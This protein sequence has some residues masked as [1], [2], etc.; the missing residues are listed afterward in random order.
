MSQYIV[1]IDLG[2]THT[3]V[4]YALS[5]AK[6]RPSIQVLEIPQQVG[7]GQVAAPKMLP[8]ARYHLSPDELPGSMA[9]LPW[10]E[11]APS[12]PTEGAAALIGSWARQ[13]GA[14]SPGRLVTSA[15]S[16][17]SHAG[18]DRH[19]PVLPWGAGDDANKISPVQ[20]NA[21]YLAHVRAAW[22][23][24]FPRHPLAQQD[25]VLTVPA[26]FDESARAL[27]L[28]AAQQAGLGQLRLLEEPQA[29]FYDWSLRHR[30]TLAKDLSAVRLVLVCD[31]GGGTTDLSLIRV[32]LHDGEPQLTRIGVGDHLMLGG[33]NMDLALAHWV[34]AQLAQAAPEAGGERLSASRLAQLVER[35][36]S[37]KEQLL[38]ANAPEQTTVTLLGAGQRLVGASRSVALSR[39]T[40]EAL[41]LDGFFPLTGPDET[42]RSARR[43]IVELG[44]PY[45][46]DPAVTRHV[47]AFLRQH[48]V[49]SGQGRERVS[50]A[51][52]DALLLNGGVFHAPA[53]AERLQRQLE[54]WRGA[55][56][57]VLNNANPD[58]AVARGAVAYR[59][60]Q[61]GLGQRIRSGSARSYFLLLEGAASKPQGVCVLARGSDAG[62]PFTL[63]GQQFA[64]RLGQ[65]VRFHLYSTTSDAPGQAPY[66]LGQTVALDGE[67]FV[68]LPPIATVLQA[69]PGVLSRQQI[70]VQ[71]VS[72][73]SEVGT[74]E[75]HC[76]SQSKP[77]QRWQ[78]AFDL[79]Q[80]PA[81]PATQ[82]DSGPAQRRLQEAISVLDQVFGT[83]SRV[84]AEKAVRQCRQQ[85]EKL[86]GARENWSLAELRPLFD[87]LWQ[88]A[89]GRRRSAE[90]ERAWLNLIGYCLR[91][92][93]GDPLDAWRVQQVWS[94]FESGVQ[95][96]ADKQVCAQ[97]WTLWRRIAGG[98]DTSAQARLLQDFAAN[99][100]TNAQGQHEGLTRP[101]KGS[102]EDMLRLAASMERIPASH[103][104]EVGSWL[105]NKIQKSHGKLVNREE[106]NSAKLQLQLWVLARLGA[107]EPLYGSSHEVVPPD[108]VMP[109]LE[110]LL[111]LDWKKFEAAGFAASQIARVTDD[112][113]RDLP[114]PVR[115]RLVAR[116]T[117]VGAPTTWR[118]LLQHRVELDRAMAGRLAGESLPPGLR[119]LPPVP[120]S[121]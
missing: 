96:G 12:E 120:A 35:C 110:A 84:V 78:L 86:L 44:L 51:Y 23:H 81:E 15:K 18:V 115:E 25:L 55:P 98:L 66:V 85:L 79:R 77:D 2:T 31:V 105:L 24:R 71:L 74:L 116:L 99:L 94:L 40:L 69:D 72:M 82:A 70:T 60:A 68:Q 61:Q 4:A 26:S 89:R 104:L 83:A 102:D 117:A 113:S 29:A 109:W 53:I 39:Q 8:S 114:A 38:G 32:E 33:D 101:V 42:V 41:V 107:R 34:E 106:A 108:D 58:L 47:A 119:L 3:V 56:V 6:G 57:Q 49:D 76:V 112:R 90:H 16:W 63:E 95:Y 10:Q 14:Q 118:D 100:Q 21:S 22:D 11:A 28:E 97:W 91:P 37:A 50:L 30:T 92:G 13:R 93:F 75:L 27:T 62:Q 88:R 36:R 80:D 87:A 54:S 17:L 67:R 7:P 9:A 46:R 1:G 73:L 52:P 103:K 45:A 19:A 43:G 5:R 20:A 64:L 111:T 48:Q 59:L 121:G 65:P